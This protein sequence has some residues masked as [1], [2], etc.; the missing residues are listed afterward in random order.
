MR[1][2][3]PDFRAAQVSAVS[4]LSD[5][6]RKEDAAVLQQSRA[7]VE[8]GLDLVRG[9][10]ERRQGAAFGDPGVDGHEALF[11]PGDASG[12]AIAAPR[13]P[14]AL[15]LDVQSSGPGRR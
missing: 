7:R 10:V 5:A 14:I 8:S 3:I 4:A 15:H 12:G 9:D 11:R 1:L 2:R 13:G 6:S